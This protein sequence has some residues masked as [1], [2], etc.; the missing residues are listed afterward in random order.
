MSSRCRPTRRS[1]MGRPG[2]WARVDHL[3]HGER[4]DREAIRLRVYKKT[5]PRT[6]H[7][8]PLPAGERERVMRVVNSSI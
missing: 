8:K 6:P 5:G 1:D 2:A 4:S 7:P 3:S